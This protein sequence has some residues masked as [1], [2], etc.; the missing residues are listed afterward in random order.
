MNTVETLEVQQIVVRRPYFSA[1]SW[2]GIFAGVVVGL[3][4]N[5]ALNLLALATGLTTVDITNSRT[6][7]SNAPIWAMVWNGVAMLI[8]A[9][10]GGYVAARMSGLKR[11]SDGILH[12]F[13]AWGVTTILLTGLFAALAGALSSQLFNGVGRGSTQNSAQDNTAGQVRGSDFGRRLEALTKGTANSAQVTN[14]DPRT[15]DQLQRH[16][17]AGER[18]QAIDLMVSSMNVEPQHATSLVDQL[19]IISGSPEKAS[20]EARAAVND[21]VVAASGLTWSIVIAIVL[22]LALGVLGGALGAIGA[23]RSRQPMMVG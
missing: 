7:A 20:G 3:A 9:F 23:R 17:L 6:P 12:G 4:I 2:G 5:L 1:I 10:A 16:I 14:V 21:V 15:L 19:L 11:R 22:S 18:S 13:V 8:A